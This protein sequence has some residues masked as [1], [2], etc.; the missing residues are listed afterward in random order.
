MRCI[1]EPFASL[2]SCAF[3]FGNSSLRFLGVLGDLAVKLNFSQFFLCVSAV[4]SA[5]AFVHSAASSP[6]FA[7]SVTAADTREH[8]AVLCHFSASLPHFRRYKMSLQRL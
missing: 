2:L 3:A 4:H 7:E 6:A 1:L 8:A 5:F